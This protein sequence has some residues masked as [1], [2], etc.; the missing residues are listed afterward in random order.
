MSIS[1]SEHKILFLKNYLILNTGEN[2][3]TLR[4]W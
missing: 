3:D 4:G 1:V 2:T